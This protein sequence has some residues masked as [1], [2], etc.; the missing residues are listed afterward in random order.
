VRSAGAT[1]ARFVDV[2]DLHSADSTAT[3]VRLGLRGGLLAVETRVNFARSVFT[4]DRL[5]T[6]SSDPIERAKRRAAIRG[7]RRASPETRA[8][9]GM[10]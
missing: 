7:Y 9:R 2:S 10:L 8:D 1:V 4:L 6:R 5:R 3:G